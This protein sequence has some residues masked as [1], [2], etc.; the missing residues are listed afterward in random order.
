M[1]TDQA[2]LVLFVL[3]GAIRLDTAS[4]YN[5]CGEFATQ[6]AEAVVPVAGFDALMAEL[7]ARVATIQ[8]IVRSGFEIYPRDLLEAAEGLPVTIP[9]AYS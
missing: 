1:G 3:V 2:R 8:D 9:E 4:T 7:H 5:G 6:R